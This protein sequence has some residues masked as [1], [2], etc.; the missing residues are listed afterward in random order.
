MSGGRET[1]RLIGTT[2]PDRLSFMI[3]TKLLAPGT[4]P[5]HRK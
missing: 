5:P 4:I 1:Y 2:K 3:E